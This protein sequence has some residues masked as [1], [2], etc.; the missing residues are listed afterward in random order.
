M[1]P[2][3]VGVEHTENNYDFVWSFSAPS[4]PTGAIP[5]CLASGRRVVAVTTGLWR[6]MAGNPL[7]FLTSRWPWRGLLYAVGTVVVA[8]VLV[9][10]LLFPP[11]LLLAGVPV[12]AV[13]RRRL[14]LLK[15]APPDPHT[16]TGVRGL[17]REAATWR[18]IGYTAGL[19][20]AWLLLDVGALIVLGL[21]VLILVL[22]LAAAIHPGIV[23]IQLSGQR[24]DSVAPALAVGVLTGLPITVAGLYGVAF[25]AGAQAE[26]AEWLLAPAGPRP[27]VVELSRSRGRL[28]DAF[29]A[30]RRRIE[31]D[32]HDGAQQHLVLLTMNLGLAELEL[33]GGG[34]GRAAALVGEAHHQARLALAAIREQIRG[35]HPQV[36]TDFGLAEAVR[37]LAERCPVPVQVDLA[38]PGRLPPAIESTAYFA[39]SEAVTN[40][41][42]H[43]GATLVR[44][45][46][47]LTAGRLTLTVTDDG[48]GG[49]DP[50]SGTGLRGLADR[51]AVMDG[52]LELSSPAGG[53]TM[54]RIGMPCPCG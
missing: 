1:A 28:V 3:E 18:E 35:I 38:L 6:A 4:T 48:G 44:V 27:E 47:G 31:R 16:A 30:E 36:L 11:L 25:L 24:Y 39:V 2:R 23:N 8:A 19:L 21:G 40:V 7:R 17:I 29:E 50:T 5:W 41:A 45:A 32:L 37:E 53:P 46:G 49:A 43:A 15:P 20:G 22:P 54:L 12:G 9:P 34:G 26:F 13:E 52:T 33:A 51:I 42:R 10:L 14:G